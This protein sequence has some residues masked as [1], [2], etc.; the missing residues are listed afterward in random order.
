[1]DDLT[2][3]LRQLCQRNR[4]GSHNTQADRMRS[5][6][7]AARQL[8]EVGFRQMKASSLKGKH[9][10]ALLERWQ[11]EGLS[12][13][14]IKN[15]LSHLRWWAEKIGKSGILPADNTQL[16]VAER[17]YVTNISKAREL[18][19]S[20][21]QVTDPHVRM[22]L[23]LQAAFGLRREESI[24]FQPSYADRG[25]YIALKG[26]WT[27]GGRERIVPITTA[28]Q[29]DMLHAAHRLAGTGSLIPAH[30]TF[31]Q[32]RHVYDGQCKAAGL[33]NMHGLRHRYA[34]MRYET[35]TGW[36]SSAAGGPGK[37]QF[38]LSQRL[39]DRHARQQISRELGHKR[40][41]VTSIY[42]GG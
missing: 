9:V 37:A 17:R 3:T 28:E 22:S 15:R 39:V 7:L 25:D 41:T 33:S 21:E 42:L 27:K 14:T 30:K 6:A 19:V 24:K 13:G 5:L 18:G 20:L 12:S 2:Y 31:I 1:M 40:L 29:R 36:K 16:G 4:D 34:Q 10:Q 35:L 26:S 32:Q 11:G 8:R 38:G 23:Q